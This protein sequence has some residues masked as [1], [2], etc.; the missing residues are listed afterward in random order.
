MSQRI[1]NFGEVFT[2]DIEVNSMLA[3]VS[4]ELLRLD[5]KFFLLL[6]GEIEIF[7]NDSLE[8]KLKYIE[9]I[10]KRINGA[11]CRIR[12]CDP[13]LRRHVCLF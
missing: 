5:S 6:T 1:I 2:P 12:T 9:V 4:E 11:L 10:I 13:L 3:L 7:H 8:V